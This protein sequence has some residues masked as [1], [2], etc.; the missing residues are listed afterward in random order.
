[1][2]KPRARPASI[3]SVPPRGAPGPSARG[4]LARLS[5]VLRA[6][7]GLVADTPRA[8]LAAPRAVPPMSPRTGGE[9]NVSIAKTVG[10]SSSE[11]ERGRGELPPRTSII[12]WSASAARMAGRRAASSAKRGPRF[13]LW[14]TSA[15]KVSGPTSC[16]GRSS[17]VPLAITTGSGQSEDGKRKAAP[18]SLEASTRSPGS[19]GKVSTAIRRSSQKSLTSRLSVPITERRRAQPGVPSRS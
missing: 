4:G 15:T 13:S 16:R 9:A 8:R 3:T 18:G 6:L 1:M 19:S 2:A 12:A 14:W 7:V 17:A 10:T 5:A 11:S